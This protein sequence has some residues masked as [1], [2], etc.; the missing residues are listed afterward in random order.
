M[1][2]LERVRERAM[3]DKGVKFTA[4]MHHIDQALLVRSFWDMKRAAAPGADQVIWADYG[5]NLAG[6][7]KGLLE[8][9]R[10]GAYRPPPA[11]GERVPEDEGGATKL[12]AAGVE[13]KIVQ[14][15]VCRVLNAVYEADFI[16]FSY[17]FRPGRGCHEAL[18][19][20]AV[21]ID[22]KKV[23]W[24]LGAGVMSCFNSIAHD[25]LMRCLGERIADPR[26]LRL[27]SMWLK[28]GVTGSGS[29][30]SADLGIQQVG[31]IPPLL[32]NVLLHC[33]LDKWALHWR[34]TVARGEVIIVRHADDFVM[35][36]QHR[37]DAELFFGNLRGRLGQF[38]ITLRPD[39]TRLIEFGRFASK[40]RKERGQGKPEVFNFLG[41]THICGVDRT[42]RFKLLRITDAKRWRAKLRDLKAC[43]R[44]RMHWRIEEVA[45][46]LKGAVQGFYSYYAVPGNLKSLDSLR[47]FLGKLWFKTINRRSQKRSMTWKK[48]IDRWWGE[49]PKPKILHPYPGERFDAKHSARSPVR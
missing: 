43:L 5:N 39:K 35:G 45:E 48:F 41:F 10:S 6:N 13:D 34:K 19:A 15:A 24:V 16:G 17:G 23:N 46:W 3:K 21:A 38:R 33:V 36:F 40:N 25:E 31:A 1:T 49:I 11:P 18:D 30:F 9:L 32:A 47:Y 22:R 4:L 29:W 7:T 44:R 37:D 26:M 14:R 12:G 28:A 8:R 27:V 20:V 42:G 2:G